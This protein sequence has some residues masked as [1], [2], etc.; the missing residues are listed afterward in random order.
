MTTPTRRRSLRTRLLA[1][2]TSATDALAAAW[3]ILTRAQQTLLTVLARIRPGRTAQA[4]IRA[5]DAAFQQAIAAFDRTAMGLIERWAATDLPTAYRAGGAEALTLADRDPG[6][7]TWTPRH[8]TTITALSAQYYTDLTNRVRE[9]VRRARA[10]LRDA[11][12]AARG[13]VD[14]FRRTPWPGR[15]ALLDAH[16]LD[17][18]IYA[19]NTRHPAA[20][21][22]HAAIAWQTYTTANTGLLRTTADEVGANWIEVRDGPGCGWKSHKDDDEA[23]GSLRTIQDALAHPVAHPH[24]RRSFRPRPDVISR[25][26]YAFGGPF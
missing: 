4:A 16:P 24:C 26:D 25:T 23:D 20:A 13:R 8:Q 15:A 1:L 19:G 6:Q 7:W 3:R 5:A 18:V 12:T 17:T 14:Q 2:I 9:A 11:L 22:A 10:F 21:W